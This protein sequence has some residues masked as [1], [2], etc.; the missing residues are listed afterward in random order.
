[1]L[2]QEGVSDNGRNS[3][4]LQNSKGKLPFT[5]LRQSVVNVNPR[6]ALCTPTSVHHRARNGA[7][8][9]KVPRCSASSEGIW[10]EIPSRKA[11]GGP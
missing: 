7:L 4:G 8:S 2:C 11:Q 1:M 5:K 9:L 10:S 6:S 3:D